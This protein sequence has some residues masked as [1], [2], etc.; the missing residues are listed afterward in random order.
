MSSIAKSNIE[1]C[2]RVP[3]CVT[4]LDD[5]GKCE[6]FYSSS[7]NAL[8]S[9]ENANYWP[10]VLNH[11]ASALFPIEQLKSIAQENPDPESCANFNKLIQTYQLDG[12]EKVELVS[13]EVFETAKDHLHKVTDEL[14]NVEVKLEDASG[15]LKTTASMSVLGAALIALGALGVYFT[16]ASTVSAEGKPSQ[17]NYSRILSYVSMVAG[18]ALVVFSACRSTALAEHFD[19]FLYSLDNQ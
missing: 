11:P 10:R 3:G 18:L 6:V 9:T 8:F 17:R 14:E 4:T 2:P 15:F 16:Q 7:K 19:K 13:R 1:N 12:K 5:D